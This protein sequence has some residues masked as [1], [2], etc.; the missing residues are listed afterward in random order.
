MEIISE[1]QGRSYS[2]TPIEMGKPVTVRIEIKEAAVFFYV[3]DRQVQQAV[4]DPKRRAGAGVVFEPSDAI[5]ST[6]AT[7]KF[8]GFST[9]SAPGRIWLPEINPDMKTQALTVPRFRKER[10]PRHAL[11]AS[12]GDVLRGE[13]EG[14]TPTHF[15]F[16]S[17]LE[18]LRIPRAR[19]SAAIWLKPPG[20]DTATAETS[21]ASDALDRMFTRN[22]SYSGTSLATLLSVITREIPGVTFDNKAG[23]AGNRRV[24]MRFSRQTVRELLDQICSLFDVRYRIGDKG[25]IT[26]ESGPEPAKKFT[27]KSYWLK[28]DAYPD[29]DAPQKSLAQKGLEFPEGTSAKWDAA[30]RRLIVKQTAAAQ[31]KIEAIL[32]KEHGANYSV[33]THW[34]L[35]ANGG[36]IGLAVEKFG[37]DFITGQHPE[38]GRCRI[39]TPLVFTIQ[40]AKPAATNTM[41]ALANWRLR[42]AR[43]PVIPESGGESSPTLAKEAPVFKLPLLAGGDF[44][45]KAEQGKVVVL[46]FWATWCGPCIKS[47]PGL[48]EAISAFPAERVKLIGLNQGEPA[49]TVKQFLQTRGWNLTVAM[50]SAQKIAQQ[51]GVNGIPHTV[52]VGPDGKVAW[53]K[54]GYSP[55]GPAEAAEAI[56]KLLEAPAPEAQPQ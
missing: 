35:L 21:S 3:G 29:A 30:A 37:K 1:G 11:V 43:E 46:D 55:E 54:T 38:Y 13:I 32:K 53:V 41:N 26:I 27:E 49:D 24:A 47:L 9:S 28:G 51:Y 18:K 40:T 44:D 8:T 50:D 20:K 10:P 52:I 42:P 36:R 34:L 4:C 56:K 14:T 6:S 22:M 23:S 7:V 33:L 25:A 2:N 48:I 39:P 16:L 31:A 19:V 15:G 5:F 17:G 12:N 45:L